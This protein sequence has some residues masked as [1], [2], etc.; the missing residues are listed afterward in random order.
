MDVAE[1]GALDVLLGAASVGAGAARTVTAPL[2]LVVRRGVVRSRRLWPGPTPD[3]SALG[4]R[5]ERVRG[6]LERLVANILREVVRR[7]VELV[8]EVVDLTDVV[9]RHVD[10]DA[11]VRDVDLGAVVDRVDVDAVV[12]RV[13]VEGVVARVDVGA[14][15]SRVDLDEL[16]AKVD[17]DAVASRI[18]VDSVASRLD[19]SRVIARLNLDEVAKRLDV[20]A[21]VAR[22]D[23]DAV[24]GRLD[25]P[26]IA[27]KVVTA[28]DLPEIVREAAGP[29]SSEVV[30]GLRT[31]GAQADDVVARMVDRLLRRGRSDRGEGRQLL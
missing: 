2:V 1:R 17:L 13:D 9:R 30:R 27:M 20:D 6:E 18:D 23:L 22:V 31:E 11:I 28:I 29:A 15:V 7:V 26:E 25:L 8:L 5:G 14:V 19:L 10:L 21:V 4:E 12:D 16:V 3:L 24:L